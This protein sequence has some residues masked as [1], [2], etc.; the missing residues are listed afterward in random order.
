MSV[1]K[2]TPGPWRMLRSAN[3][4]ERW[5]IGIHA[6][7]NANIHA[8]CYAEFASKG[9]VRPAECEANARLIAAAPEL[10]DALRYATGRLA[11]AAAAISRLGCTCDAAERHAEDCAGE[12][13]A[14]DFDPTIERARALLA[15]LDGEVT[16]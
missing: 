16:P 14:K 12:N 10:R 2:A 15:R 4:G 8:E 6:E 9:D 11:V 7:P 13:R 3:P 1:S 5:D